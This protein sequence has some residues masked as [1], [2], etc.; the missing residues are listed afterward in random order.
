MTLAR[1]TQL[2]PYEIAFQ[3]ASGGMGVVYQTHDPRLE[4]QVAIKLL[5]PDLTRSRRTRDAIE[6]YRLAMLHQ[7]NHTPANSRLGRQPFWFGEAAQGLAH[8]AASLTP[9]ISRD[10]ALYVRAGN[11]PWRAWQP[12]T[13]AAVAWAGASGDG[14]R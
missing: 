10:Q 1:G 5:P 8:M 7:P 6:Q 4:R 12:R 2:D 14:L 11:D 9:E 3:L 13:S